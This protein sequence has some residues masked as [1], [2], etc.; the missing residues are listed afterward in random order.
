LKNS[1]FNADEVDT[2]MLQRLQD[3]MDSGDLQVIN[4]HKDGDGAQFLSISRGL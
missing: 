2:D 4:M 1:D 3:A